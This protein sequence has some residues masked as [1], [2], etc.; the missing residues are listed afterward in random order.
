VIITVDHQLTA[1]ANASE[2]I[3][4][5]ASF[6]EGD[7]T[8]VNNEGRAQRFFQVY[9][10]VYYKPDVVLYESWRWIHA[11]HTTLEQREIEWTLL[12]DVTAHCAAANPRLAGI[13]EAAP[14]ADF[15]IKGLKI[16]RAPRRFSGR[17]ANRALISVHEP[18]TPQDADSP[19]AFSMEGYAGPNEPSPLIPFAWAP[20]WNSPQAWNKFQVEVGG[21]LR[22]G[23][24]GVRLIEGR[25][26]LGYFG[27]VPTKLEVSGDL[28]VVPLY[29]IYGSE[30]LS[31]RAQPVQQQISAA[32]IALSS[33]DAG[34]LGLTDGMQA[35]VRIG[36][37]MSQFAVRVSQTLP[38]GLV[39]LP[40]GI[41]GIATLAGQQAIVGAGA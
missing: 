39:G 34:R 33:E 21:H 36:A 40:I 27:K 22:A 4:P 6:A 37:E 13:V 26:E 28:R 9:D 30:E 38:A 14:D 3:L 25:S 18:R 11:L 23:D 12:D 17:T 32:Y 2:Y 8:L 31:S 16:A 35:S 19:L 1:T 5:A 7:G 15:R 29:H 24:S 41:S 20:G 10:P